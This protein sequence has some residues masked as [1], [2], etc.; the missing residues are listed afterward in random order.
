MNTSFDIGSADSHVHT[1]Y[2][3]IHIGRIEEFDVHYWDQGVDFPD[4]FIDHN[5]DL[6]TNFFLGNSISESLDISNDTRFL[7]KSSKC[8]KPNDL[9]FKVPSIESGHSCVFAVDKQNDLYS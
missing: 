4:V 7:F 9:N 2:Y 5:C 1:E 8:Q 3:R 6:I